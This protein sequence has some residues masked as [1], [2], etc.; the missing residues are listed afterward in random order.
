MQVNYTLA[1]LSVVYQTQQVSIR[2]TFI[3]VIM[4]VSQW[5][6]GE[7]EGPGFDSVG[8]LYVICYVSL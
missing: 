8:R 4:W 3:N 6:R 5:L 2:I 7:R 1:V